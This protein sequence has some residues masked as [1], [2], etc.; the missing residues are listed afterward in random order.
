MTKRR[1]IPRIQNPSPKEFEQFAIQAQPVIVEGAIADWKA[2]REWS[3]D[4]FSRLLGEMPV[5]Y[6][7]APSHIH[8]DLRQ[9]DARR[10]TLLGRVLEALRS[11]TKKAAPPQTGSLGEYLRI[12]TSSPE[13]SRYFLPGDDLMMFDRGTWSPQL[14]ALR[15]DFSVPRFFREERLE[16]S[17]LWLSGKGVHSRLHYDTNGCHNLNAQVT[18][19]KQVEMFSPDQM[20]SLYPYY[21]TKLDPYNFSQVD[22]EAVDHARFPKFSEAECH[23]GQLNAGDMLF[24]PAY[25]F[26]SFLHAGAF[27]ANLNFW[28]RP[29]FTHLSPVAVRAAVGFA[30]QKVFMRSRFPPSLGLLRWAGNLEEQVIRNERP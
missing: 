11:R 1:Q 22:L 24:V 25:W 8:P 10:G 28:W 17:G 20:E 19:Q 29:D 13:A 23:E 12:I 4:Y 18:G 30:A 14:T 5:V 27:N 3:P 7:Q 6:K 15:E 16:T 9:F 2:V 21:Y 26:H